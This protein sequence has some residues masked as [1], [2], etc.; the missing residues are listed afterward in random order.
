MPGTP[1]FG[2]TVT[3]GKFL[4][5]FW[6]DPVCLRAL[7]FMK[8]SPISRHRTLYHKPAIDMP[9]LPA[10]AYRAVALRPPHCHETL[11]LS[12][13]LDYFRRSLRKSSIAAICFSPA[14][15]KAKVSTEGV[16]VIALDRRR[17]RAPKAFESDRTYFEMALRDIQ[18][19]PNL[20]GSAHIN[21]NL[22]AQFIPQYFLTPGCYTLASSTGATRKSLSSPSPNLSP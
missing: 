19:I 16:K 9:H 12:R 13:L 7:P 22:A 6:F 8:P 5:G 2:L 17:H 1:V 4:P 21:L 18:L 15:Q 20:E 11:C 3:L 14:V 10:P